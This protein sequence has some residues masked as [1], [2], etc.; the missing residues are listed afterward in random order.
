VTEHQSAHEQGIR[1]LVER[2]SV[3]EGNELQLARLLIPRLQKEAQE[4][5]GHNRVL[6]AR[7]DAAEAGMRELRDL[8]AAGEE[9][10]GSDGQ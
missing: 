7:L 2:L 1:D 4:A 10:K 5:E 8:I 9:E 6:Q 3:A